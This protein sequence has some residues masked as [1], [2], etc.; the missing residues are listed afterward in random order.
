MSELISNTNLNNI[1]FPREYPKTQGFSPKNIIHQIIYPE[2]SPLTTKQVKKTYKILGEILRTVKNR[3]RKGMTPEQK[4][5]LVYKIIKEKGYTLKENPGNSLFVESL[6]SPKKILDCDASSFVVLGV[7]Q[8]LKWPV[9]LVQLPS[10]VFVRWQK[11]QKAINIDYG[12]IKSDL[13][14]FYVSLKAITPLSRNGIISLAYFNCGLTKHAQN[15]NQEAIKYY[16]MA[17]IQNP[18]NTTAL[19]NR[20]ISNAALGRY[21]EAYMDYSQVIAIDPDF[22]SAYR[23][24]AGASM[25]QEKFERAIKDYNKAIKF[26]PKEAVLYANRGEAYLYSR[27]YKRALE[28]YN[29]AI[30]LGGINAEDYSAR[31]MIWLILGQHKTGI[32]DMTKAIELDPKHERYIKG[33]GLLGQ[34][35]ICYLA[36]KAKKNLPPIQ[37]NYG[38]SFQPFPPTYKGNEK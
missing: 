30:T 27:K 9:T 16:N 35:Y 22:Q 14:Y 8:E 1:F 29:Q 21:E 36:E 24:R 26:S 13:F 12:E 20:G 31:S 10:H 34:Q 32:E 11:G 7:A 2:S 3:L 23:N 38:C 33:L 4:L 15:Q 25:R 5:K 18:N 37:K 6:T 28:D 19:F 17:I